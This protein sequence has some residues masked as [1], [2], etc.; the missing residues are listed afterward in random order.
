MNH[1]CVGYDDLVG[2][3]MFN[4]AFDRLLVQSKFEIFA[5]QH[6][7]SLVKMVKRIY[8]NENKGVI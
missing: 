1:S 2:F 5:T 3:F 8:L 4:V 7:Q 6:Y